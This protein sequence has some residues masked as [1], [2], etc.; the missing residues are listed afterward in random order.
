MLHTVS[1][2]FVCTV[3]FRYGCVGTPQSNSPSCLESVVQEAYGLKKWCKIL[4]FVGKLKKYNLPVMLECVERERVEE[5]CKKREN[6]DY[7]FV[8]EWISKDLF[9]SPDKT[10]ISV[11]VKGIFMIPIESGVKQQRLSFVPSAQDNF[12]R[13]LVN[14]VRRG[15]I[16]YGLL[17]LRE[18]RNVLE[19]IYYDPYTV[20]QTIPVNKIG[21]RGKQ[22][23]TTVRLPIQPTQSERGNVEIF[24][25][26]RAFPFCKL[27]VMT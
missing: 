7:Q 21:N 2:Y 12:T 25:I 4:F 14:L 1:I 18:N 10:I 24:I 9:L 8:S 19:E 5:V 13:F 23:V 3:C 17:G 11:D 22:P 15:E 26:K 20:R 6:Y 16:T 27:Q